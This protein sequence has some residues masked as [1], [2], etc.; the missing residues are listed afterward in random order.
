MYKLKSTC[1]HRY[2]SWALLGHV[3]IWIRLVC[4][5]HSICRNTTFKPGLNAAHTLEVVSGII[6]VCTNAT[7]LVA[8]FW[9]EPMNSA[10]SES[11]KMDAVNS[12]V[13]LASRCS[14]P[15]F[16]RQ[17]D[18]QSV[19]MQYLNRGYPAQKKSNNQTRFLRS[20]QNTA[21]NNVICN[22]GNLIV[23]VWLLPLHRGS[24]VC[25]T[26]RPR[27]FPCIVKQKDAGGTVSLLSSTAQRRRW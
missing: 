7:I 16:Q 9:F 26:L 23:S 21:A 22:T 19:C 15:Q 10:G 5:L 18:V 17:Q 13:C 24:R 2:C 27:D 4:T 12:R 14:H 1:C 6:Y 3:W 11:H 25:T 8:H 20:L